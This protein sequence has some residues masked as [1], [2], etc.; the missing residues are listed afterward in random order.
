MVMHLNITLT[1]IVVFITSL[2]SYTQVLKI[3]AYADGTLRDNVE[4][5]IK[6]NSTTGIDAS[7]G[8]EDISGNDLLEFE[9]RILQRD[10]INFQ[11]L[12]NL[13]T[14][15]QSVPIYFE[16]SFDSKKNFRKNN[17]PT[18]IFFEVK[19]ETMNFDRFELL[20]TT[21]PLND[22][23]TNI[24]TYDT[25]CDISTL[26]NVNFETVGFPLDVLDFTTMTGQS[27]ESFI[28]SFVIEF[29]SSF[30]ISSLN[31]PSTQ[32]SFKIFPNPA[33]DNL[34]ITN[35]DYQNIPATKA[36]LFSLDGK[37]LSEDLLPEITNRIDV[38]SINSGLYV[39]VVTDIDNNVYREKI[40]VVK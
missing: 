39:L 2:N 27:T 25:D 23:I 10:S 15:N 17:S 40:V 18:S 36:E 34:F 4:L 20:S 6:A 35:L 14:A 32:R 11:C 1:L 16:Q 33:C 13:N 9:I 37:L 29:D 21:I 19:N 22:F 26:L 28:S 5:G 12:H 8:E 31:L 38:S 7:L 3:N 24:W 30:V